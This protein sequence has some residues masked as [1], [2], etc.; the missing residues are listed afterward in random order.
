MTSTVVFAKATNPS[1][2]GSVAATGNLSDLGLTS[3]R[4]RVVVTTNLTGTIAAGDLNNMQLQVGATV[5]GPLAVNPTANTYTQNPPIEVDVPD[6]TAVS[7]TAIGN[8]SGASA[9][10]GAQIVA[11]P[12][13]QGQ[14]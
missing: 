12:L 3:N 9:V 13:W 7:V 4:W 10:Y 6:Q 8:A 5:I 11:T 14:D 2:G 1:A